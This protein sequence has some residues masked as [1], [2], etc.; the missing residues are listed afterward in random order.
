VTARKAK[1]PAH[2]V[3]EGKICPCGILH[4][5]EPI[6]KPGR[7]MGAWQ[8]VGCG[9]PYDDREGALFCAIN[10]KQRMLGLK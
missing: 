1:A 4:Y 7:L 9:R 10:D 2:S 5:V 8:C 6:K 3:G